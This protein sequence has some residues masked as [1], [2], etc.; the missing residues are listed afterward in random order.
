MLIVGTVWED[1]TAFIK[2]GLQ[3]G[4]GP[5]VEDKNMKES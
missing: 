5:I 1:F 3:A 4:T 2:L